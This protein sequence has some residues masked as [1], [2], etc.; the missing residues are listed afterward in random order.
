[1]KVY[2]IM[3]MLEDAL[4]NRLLII[5]LIVSDDYSTIRAILKHL[6]KVERGQILKSS[7]GKINE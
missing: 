6:S 7:K 3:K 4:Y 1:M 2:A 5:D